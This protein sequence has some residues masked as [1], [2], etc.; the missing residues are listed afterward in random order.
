[1]ETTIIS[2]GSIGG[3]IGRMEIQNGNYQNTLRL[4]WDHIGIVE[5]KMETTVVSWGYI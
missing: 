4:Y 1:M 3:S 5:N 2:L